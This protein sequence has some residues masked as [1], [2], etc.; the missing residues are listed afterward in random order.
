MMTI[1][2]TMLVIIFFLLFWFE[3]VLVSLENC[4][5][6]PLVFN[7]IATADSVLSRNSITVGC[8]TISWKISRSRMGWDL[9]PASRRLVLD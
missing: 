3:R 7:K 9:P 8:K 2:I 5:K 6:I 1:M 4:L